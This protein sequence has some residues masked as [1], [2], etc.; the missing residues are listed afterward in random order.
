MAKRAYNPTRFERVHGKF[1]ESIDWDDVK[2]RFAITD[3][4]VL[5]LKSVAYEFKW[6]T[7]QEYNRAQREANHPELSIK[8]ANSLRISGISNGSERHL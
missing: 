3:R 8:R 5:E 4:Q 6:T 1:T 2:Q 7:T